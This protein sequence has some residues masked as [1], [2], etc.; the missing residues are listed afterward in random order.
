M[1]ETDSTLM[2]HTRVPSRLSDSER[3]K[4]DLNVAHLSALNSVCEREILERERE[5]REREINER[6]IETD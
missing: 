1:R 4:E 3:G 5:M 6:E 2:P